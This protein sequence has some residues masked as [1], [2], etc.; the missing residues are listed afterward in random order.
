[1][2]TETCSQCK[3]TGK[4]QKLKEDTYYWVRYDTTWYICLHRN[5]DFID[6][7]CPHPVTDADK[8]GPEVKKPKEC[9]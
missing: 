8:I 9:K 4:V 5:G 6:N 7:D 2:T 1:M 3:G